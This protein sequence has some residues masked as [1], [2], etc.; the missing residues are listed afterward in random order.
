MSTITLPVA[1]VFLFVVFAVA[2]GL[3]LLVHRIEV[4]R[5]HRVGELACVAGTGT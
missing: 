5:P 3:G 2:V 1:L 4:R